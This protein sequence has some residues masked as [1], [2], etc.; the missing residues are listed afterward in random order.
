ML[1]DLYRV[2]SWTR[3][4]LKETFNR[5]Y[6]RKK[7]MT[8]FFLRKLVLP[9]SQIHNSH[10]FT[11]HKGKPSSKKYDPVLKYKL[12]RSLCTF[13]LL[14]QTHCAY[15]SLLSIFDLVLNIWSKT[16]IFLLIFAYAKPVLKINTSLHHQCSLISP[17]AL[18]CATA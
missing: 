5:G 15:R 17:C 6:N 2:T 16:L 4:K 12:L 7:V 18:G 8:Y 1:T 9:M 14:W 3:Y 10:T 11:A 13:A